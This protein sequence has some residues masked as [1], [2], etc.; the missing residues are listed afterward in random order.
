MELDPELF[1]SQSRILIQNSRE[2]WNPDQD[3]K[4]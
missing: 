1:A 2:K 3:F 4:K